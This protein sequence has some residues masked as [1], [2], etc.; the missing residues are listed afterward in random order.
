MNYL[1]HFVFNHAVRGL[2]PQPY[3][4]L[5][6]ALPDLWPRF[7]RTR[8]IRWAAVRATP[9]DG[10]VDGPLRAGLINHVEADRRFH[11]LPCFLGWQQTLKMHLASPARP[12]VVLDFLAHLALELALD[13]QLVCADRH[14]PERFYAHLGDCDLDLVER[15]LTVIAAVDARGLG[16]V[17]RG[18]LARRFLLRYVDHDALLVVIHQLLERLPIQLPPAAWLRELLDAAIALARPHEVW[19]EL[20]AP[21]APPSLAVAEASAAATSPP[22]SG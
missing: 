19:H 4:V 16:D 20:A 10:P 6:V 9:A 11:S 7:S 21:A 17:V 1:S 14:L 3:F 13:R 15:R 2:A 22:R 12:A 8:R 18:F 5:G